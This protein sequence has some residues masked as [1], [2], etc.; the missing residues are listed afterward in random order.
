MCKPTTCTATTPATMS[1]KLKYAWHT[2]QSIN[3]HLHG[4]TSTSVI[5]SVLMHC[6]VG[7]VLISDSLGT[8]LQWDLRTHTTQARWDFAPYT[9]SSIAPDPA[10]EQMK[11]W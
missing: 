11:G 5:A 4:V 7:L 6:R 9:V 8:V 10:G 1:G 2:L 3:S